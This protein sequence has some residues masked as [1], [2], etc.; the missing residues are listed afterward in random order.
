M[1]RWNGRILQRQWVGG[2]G[3][4]RLLTRRF[5]AQVECEARARP[6]RDE[7]NAEELEAAF[8]ALRPVGVPV[9][10]RAAVSY[11][12]GAGQLTRSERFMTFRTGHRQVATSPA[13]SRIDPARV[14]RTSAPPPP[15]GR[16]CTRP[17][18]QPNDRPGT[19]TRP[20]GAFH[21]GCGG[22]LGRTRIA[23]FLDPGRLAGPAAQ[24]IQL[25]AAHRTPAHD[26]NRVYV[27][28]VEGEHALHAL[29]ERDF[30]PR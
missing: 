1:H 17:T 20:A 21:S 19:P 27:G 13:A 11:R 6:P 9:A 15:P 5:F 2:D 29:A 3:R 14:A 23:A 28:R 24:V 8:A 7:L 26:L 16:G 18:R 22:V 12:R 30:P 25:G 4:L 10:A